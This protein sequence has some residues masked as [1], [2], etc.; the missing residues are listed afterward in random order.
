MRKDPLAQAILNGDIQLEQLLVEE[1]DKKTG[2]KFGE[3]MYAVQ[4]EY[5]DL[6]D[7]LDDVHNHINKT[8]DKEQKEQFSR[9]LAIKAKDMASRINSKGTALL[10]KDKK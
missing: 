10:G 8:E 6:I 7:A 9:Q 2:A 1:P 3:L 4:Q 5:V